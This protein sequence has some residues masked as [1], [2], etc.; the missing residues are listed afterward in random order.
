MT[1]VCAHFLP[2]FSSCHGLLALRVLPRRMQLESVGDGGNCGGGG[3]YV[4][5]SGGSLS[6]LDDTISYC[7]IA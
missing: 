6:V 1:L 5:E 3:R 7:F 4:R 2:S